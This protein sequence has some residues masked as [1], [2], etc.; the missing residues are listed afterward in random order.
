MRVRLT[1]DQPGLP[2][3]SLAD[4]P[5]KMARALIGRGS[6]SAAKEQEVNVRFRNDGIAV[7]PEIAL[8]VG[9]AEVLGHRGVAE[10][11]PPIT[12][13]ELPAPKVDVPISTPPPAVKKKAAST[14]RGAKRK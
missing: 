3:G 6:A 9:I 2:S 7:G 11:V 4:L 10:I 1:S 8:P 5:E 13:V 14:G 12:V